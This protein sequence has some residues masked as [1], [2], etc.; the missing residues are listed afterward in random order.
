LAEPTRED[1]LL[2]LYESSWNNVSRAEDSLWKIFAA[3]TAL[4]AG[5]D[6]A[7]DTIGDF[8]F[9]FIMTIFSFSGIISS[10]IANSWFVR[11]MGIISNIEKEFLKFN[12]NEVIPKEW[13]K[14]KVPFFNVEN[15]WI[16]VALFFTIIIAIHVIMMDKISEQ[17]YGKMI[18][19]DV[20]GSLCVAAYWVKLQTKHKDFI[21][22]AKGKDVS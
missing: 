7:I 2:K 18:L 14:G 17:D 9:L 4:F 11:N 15:W 20:F 5:L 19:L 22:N 12:G 13:V 3:Y 16:I 21:K 1:F 8:R 10:L 6:L